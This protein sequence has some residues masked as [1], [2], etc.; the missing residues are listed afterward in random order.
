MKAAKKTCKKK[1][2]TRRAAPRAICIRASGIILHAPL[3]GRSAGCCRGWA[4][5]TK[6]RSRRHTEGRTNSSVALPE[7][8]F[9]SFA[10]TSA[11]RDSSVWMVRPCPSCSGEHRHVDY[12][13]RTS[14]A[15]YFTFACSRNNTGL[16][17]KEAASFLSLLA[18]STWKGTDADPLFPGQIWDDQE[19]LQALEDLTAAGN[20][21]QLPVAVQIGALSQGLP[22]H[23]RHT[24][25]TPRE[26]ARET[27]PGTFSSPCAGSP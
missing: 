8:L 16:K 23:S 13:F 15:R 3:S 11:P 17:R 26:P 25:V 20:Q 14:A 6:A 5:V 18:Y 24:A 10:W 27:P 1:N 7:R 19:L 2:P 21:G 22:R 9:P 4:P 12:L